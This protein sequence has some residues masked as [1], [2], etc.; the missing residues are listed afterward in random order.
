MSAALF[1]TF[2]FMADYINTTG[3]SGS[4]AW[5]LGIVGMASIVGRLGL[6]ALAGKLDIIDLFRISCLALGLSYAI[7]IVAGT[8]YVLLIAFAVMLGVA[9]G[10]IIALSPAVVA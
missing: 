3:V 10:G 5:L 2:V 4:A 8:N 1:T 9:Y 6:G 7:W